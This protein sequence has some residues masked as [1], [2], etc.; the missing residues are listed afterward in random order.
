[1]KKGD[2]KQMQMQEKPQMQGTPPYKQEQGNLSLQGDE[3]P[4]WIPSLP[5]P[6]GTEKKTP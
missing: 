5:L 4:S 6:H 2:M 1:M 3:D